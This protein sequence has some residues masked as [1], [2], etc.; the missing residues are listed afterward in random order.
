MNVRAELNALELSRSELL[1][2]VRG[3]YMANGRLITQY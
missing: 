2:E 1:K 3:S